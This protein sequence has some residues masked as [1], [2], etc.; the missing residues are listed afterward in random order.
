MVLMPEVGRRRGFGRGHAL[1]VSFACLLVSVIVFL[2]LVTVFFV[3][4]SFVRFSPT[5]QH[6]VCS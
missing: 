5:C 3:E 2:R 4:L 6:P 1:S